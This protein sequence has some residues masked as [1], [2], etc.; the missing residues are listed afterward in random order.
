MVAAPVV[1][2][3]A[4][5]GALLVLEYQQQEADAWVQHTFEVRSDIQAVHLL[6][7]DAGSAVRGYLVTRHRD[8]LAPYQA[9]IAGVPQLFRGLDALTQDNPVQ[10]ARVRRLRGLARARLDALAAVLRAF[11]ES[12]GPAELETS[13]L[14]SNL[15]MQQLRAELSSMQAEEDLLLARR[16]GEA[17]RA[18]TRMYLLIGFGT[19][20]GLL[21]GVLVPMLAA[22][23]VVRRMTALQREAEMLARRDPL[24]VRPL[25]GDEIGKLGESLRQADRLL[26]ERET[27]LQETEH[28][29]QRLIETSPTAIFRQ[30]PATMAVTYV[31]PNS[32]RILGYTPEEITASPSFWLD[33]IHPEDRERVLAEDRQAIERHASGLVIEYRMRHKNG[34]YLWL[35]SF[36][37]LEYDAHGAPRMLLG[38]RLD[39]TGRKQAEF[40][41]LERQVALDATNKEL[42]AF[43]YSVS[44]DLRAPLRAVDGFSRILLEEHAA[45]LGAEARGHLQRVRDA[46]QRMAALIDDLLKL[47]RVTRAQMSREI[48]DLSRLAGSISQELRQSDP[49]RLVEFLIR[50]GLAAI[51]DPGLLRVLLQN[52]LGNSWKFTSGHP[53]ARIEF[54]L[55]TAENGQA[56]YF[57]RDDGAG[58]DP[59]YGRKLFGAFQRLHSMHEFPG[60]GIGLATVQR[61]VQ[62]H[63]GTVWGDGAVGQGATFYFTLQPGPVDSSRYSHVS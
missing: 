29:L 12:A 35:R 9:C 40:Q 60:T 51:G 59:A 56:I 33:H 15:V 38:H 1:A 21:G 24:P 27:Q 26:A 16:R 63:G 52:L 3:L 36:V 11:D 6:L 4:A 61:I 5:G 14:R 22:T 18:R 34:E 41:L 44:H 23:G 25:G 28:F 20:F 37:S 32:V 53:T 42:E 49:N 47:S 2:L 10:A 39:I 31:S 57:V 8:M 48:V 55:A 19:L 50:P 7:A 17:E 54:G 45:G 46:T 30:D 43:S 58:F 13:L 62:R